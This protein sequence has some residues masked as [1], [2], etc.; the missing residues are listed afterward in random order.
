M[1]LIL[2]QRNTGLI[3]EQRSFNLVN[4]SREQL[5]NADIVQIHQ[6]KHIIIFLNNKHMI[7]ILIWNMY[8][9]YTCYI[10]ERQF[11]CYITFI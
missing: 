9:G 1:F 10:S 4:V 7:Q 5:E 11:F 6:K 8:I 2:E 3:N